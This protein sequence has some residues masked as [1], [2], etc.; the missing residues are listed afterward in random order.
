MTPI[1]TKAVIVGAHRDAEAGRYGLLAQRQMAR[2][3]N[4]ILKKKVISFL[5]D[6]TN[7]KLTAKQRQSRLLNK[8]VIREIVCHC[9][10][11][12]SNFV[13]DQ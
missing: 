3:L 8:I 5:F 11:H 6:L 9:A 10:C 7:F 13:D 1:G 12:L 2:P 4:Q